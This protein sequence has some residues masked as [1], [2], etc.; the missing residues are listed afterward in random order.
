MDEFDYIIVGAGSAGCALADRLS[1]NLKYRI[2]IVEA[3]GSDHS[4]WIKIPIGY[5]I[6]FYNKNVNWKFQMQPDAGLN[7]RKAYCPR[8]KVVGGSSS[9]NAMVYFRGLPHDFTDWKEAAGN[10]WGWEDVRAEYDKLE[11]RVS[12]KG[13]VT[14]NGPLFV[15]DVNDQCHPTTKYFFEVAKELGLPITNDMH[16]K[17][18]GI[19]NYQLNTRKGMRWSA[20]DA[21]LRPALKRKN[22]KLVSHARTH[23]ILFKGKRAVGIA[24]EKNGMMHNV[25]ANKEVVLSAG[26]IHSPQILQLSGIGPANNLK[27]LGVDVVHANEAVGGNMQDH[28]A[29]SFYFKATEP[30]LNNKLAPWWGKALAGM[31]YVLT[32][33]GPLSL[34][35]NQC[36]GFV[37]SSENVSAPDMQLYLNPVTYTTSVDDGIIIPDSF[38]GFITCFQPCRPTSRGRVDIASANVEDAPLI[39]PNFLSTN[40][41]MEDILAGTKLMK[42][43]VNSKA[44]QP[45]IKSSMYQDINDLIDDEAMINDFKERCGTV[46]HPVSTCMMGSDENNSVVDHRLKVRGIEGLRVADASIFPNVTSGNTN[47]PSIMVGSKAG[48]LILEDAKQ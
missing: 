12:V 32:R 34:S 29:S 5:G 13:K 9:I 39:K 37:R 40:K 20:A 30:T 7:G 36:G 14:G 15:S 6:N 45:L 24:Y 21:F 2:L 17:N 11:T 1:E 10:G 46:Y 22:V 42:K 8:G 35:V 18:E 19:A 28:L 25:K 23:K 43:I 33:R 31:Q 16:A 4:P 44:L 41:D 26:A 47:A 38:P 27:A 3:G 48:R